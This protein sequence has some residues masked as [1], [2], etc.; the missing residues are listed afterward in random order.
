MIRALS[1]AG[2]LAGAMFVGAAIG[3]VI[4]GMIKLGKLVTRWLAR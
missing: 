2:F 3:F 1:V 4:E